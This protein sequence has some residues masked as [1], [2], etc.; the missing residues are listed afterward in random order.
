VRDEAVGTSLDQILTDPLRADLSSETIAPFE[1]SDGEGI[2]TLP[3]ELH[4]AVRRAQASD[5][6]P[7]DDAAR[8]PVGQFT[9]GARRRAA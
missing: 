5:A 7:D 9:H 2:A 1:Q 3:A 8:G 4:E 6:S